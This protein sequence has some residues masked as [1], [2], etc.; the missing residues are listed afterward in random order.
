MTIKLKLSILA[1]GLSVSLIF[2]STIQVFAAEQ[3]ANVSLAEQS[4]T[5]ECPLS[6]QFTIDDMTNKTNYFSGRIEADEPIL[7]LGLQSGQQYRIIIETD[8]GNTCFGVLEVS[9]ED[10]QQMGKLQLDE[11]DSMPT[12]RS[13]MSIAYETESNNSIKKANSIYGDTIYGKIEKK[14]IGSDIDYFKITIP[15]DGD[16]AFV[17]DDI[18]AGKDYDLALYNSKSKKIATSSTTADLEIIKVSDAKENEVYYAMV[19]GY[20]KASDNSNSY[21]LQYAPVQAVTDDHGNKQALATGIELTNIETLIGG[22]ID[23]PKDIDFFAFTAKASGI[24]TVYTTGNIDTV[25]CIYDAAATLLAEN[26]NG[27]NWNFSMQVS[28]DAGEQYFVAVKHAG[29]GTGTYTLN[30]QSP[31]FP[32]PSV[33]LGGSLEMATPIEIDVPLEGWLESNQDKRYV[34][35]TPNETGSYG[36]YTEGV[37][38]TYGVLC[39]ADQTVLIKNDNGIDGKNFI[40][41]DTLLAGENYFVE[42]STLYSISTGDQFSITLEQ[43]TEPT[44]DRFPAQWHMLNTLTGNDINI[45]PVWKYF[46]GSGVTVGIADT[47]TDVEHVDLKANINTNLSYNFVHGISDVFP[48]GEASSSLSAARGHGT[49]VA[50]IVAAANNG[51]GTVGVSPNASIVSLKVLGS[52]LPECLAENDIVASIKSIEYAQQ[53]DIPIIN[54]SLGGGEYSE[55][56]RQTMINASEILF[57]IAAGNYGRNLVKSAMYPAC[58]YLDNSIVVAN[59]DMD[60]KLYAG[61]NYGGPTHIAAPGTAIMSTMPNGMYQTTGGTSM[62]APVVAGVAALVKNK[63]PE[64]TPIQIR[65]RIVAESNVDIQM[66][67]SGKVKSGGIINA[68]KAVMNPEITRETYSIEMDVNQRQLMGLS[69]KDRIKQTKEAADLDSM[70]EYLIVNMVTG[71]NA[72]EF[73]TQVQIDHGFVKLVIKSELSIIDSIVVECESTAEASR[74]VDVLNE[75]VEVIYAEPDYIRLIHE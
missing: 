14:L 52:E 33:N 66:D 72:T 1:L 16:Y 51:Y 44:D 27:M 26:D 8:E 61:S 30:I 13:V 18:P 11:L 28:L 48:V 29:I 19:E 39:T 63:H 62:A 43:Y 67:M 21:R 64:F 49:H 60:G 42:I 55:S 36:F 57:V 22:V 37:C 54:M 65:N 35:F 68:F 20:K 50:G 75:Y 56:E 3:T 69:V 17:L 74:A 5:V 23:Y 10:G 71:I 7:I 38:D 15:S 6:G 70:T 59:S 32:N 53:Y 58:Y 40:V 2:S 73:L 34:V 47:G 31:Q 9:I 24:H 25:G 12:G 46:T 45:L 41:A 4:C